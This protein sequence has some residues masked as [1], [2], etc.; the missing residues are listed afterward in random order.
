MAKRFSWLFLVI[1]GASTFSLSIDLNIGSV[2][3]IGSG[4][5]PLI[6]SSLICIIA[7]FGVIFGDKTEPIAVN[8]RGTVGVVA[9][10]LV[11]ITLIENIGMVPTVALSMIVAYAGQSEGGYRFFIVYAALFGVAAWLLFS[12]ALGLPIPA[13]RMP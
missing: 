7:L 9:S 3:H 10:A 2:T 6:L 12:L 13:I 11:F 5:Y 8:V 1:L 4:A